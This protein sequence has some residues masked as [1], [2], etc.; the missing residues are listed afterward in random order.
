MEAY[1]SPGYNK[2]LLKPSLHYS[3]V[4]HRKPVMESLKFLDIR[5]DS[6]VLKT[7][8]FPA[9]AMG[10]VIAFDPG[11]HCRRL[12]VGNCRQGLSKT[13]MLCDL[14]E[15]VAIYENDAPIN[16]MTQNLV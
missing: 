11:F 6:C 3:M 1:L 12:A 14:D 5:E 9:E 8:M 7:T 4:V 15:Q 2:M 13:V 16:Q 10:K